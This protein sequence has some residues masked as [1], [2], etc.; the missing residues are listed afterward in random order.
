MF[1]LKTT[2]SAVFAPQKGSIEREG[3]LEN[4]S[5]EWIRLHRL[6]GQGTTDLRVM[7]KD[8]E[9]VLFAWA[10]SAN[11]PNRRTLVHNCPESYGS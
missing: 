4:S 8:P 5:G 11:Q 7:S 1:K 6:L 10:G 3:R 2:I 9:S